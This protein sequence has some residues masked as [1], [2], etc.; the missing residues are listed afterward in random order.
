MRS[1]RTEGMATR[2]CRRATRKEPA[3][4]A[5]RAK[6]PTGRKRPAPTREAVL[7][8]LKRRRR[9][10]TSGEQIGRELGISRAAVW[11]HIAALRKEGHI[12]ESHRRRGYR[13]VRVAR[14]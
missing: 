2:A 9:T 11:K 8:L 10:Y 7:N 14:R 12:I 6:A 1:R 3:K 13:L 5:K 4:G